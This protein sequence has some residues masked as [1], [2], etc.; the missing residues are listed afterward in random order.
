MADERRRLPSASSVAGAPSERVLTTSNARQPAGVSIYSRFSKA[1]EPASPRQSED[2]FA[3]TPKQVKKGTVQCV[4]SG[5]G[6]DLR[7][8]AALATSNPGS[9]P[10]VGPVVLPSRR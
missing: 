6:D 7:L 1:A 10:R 4:T 2:L 3:A 9:C 5:R 8:S